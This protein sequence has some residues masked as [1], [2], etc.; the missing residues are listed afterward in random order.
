MCSSDLLRLALAH[1][2]LG[3]HREAV[4]AAGT[5]MGAAPELAKSAALWNMMGLS[6]R[7][8]GE[9]QNALQSFEKAAEV[10]PKATEPLL[11]AAAITVRNLGFTKTVDLLDEVLKRDPDNYWAKVTRPVAVRRATPDPAKVKEAL[12]SLD[13]LAGKTDRV[14]AHYNRCVIAQAVLTAN[15]AEVKRALEACTQ[16]LKAAQAKKAPS[17]AELQKRV[18]GLDQTVQFM[19]DDEAPKAT[20][21]LNTLNEKLK[22]DDKLEEKTLEGE[23]GP[24]GEQHSEDEIGRAHV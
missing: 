11:N 16:S 14:E 9:T 10:D 2:A 13:E 19:P 21:R 6:Y 15:K 23:E 12:A 5:G 3:Q 1:H 7:A 8:L 22:L 4:V 24:T 17:V 20:Q 18:K